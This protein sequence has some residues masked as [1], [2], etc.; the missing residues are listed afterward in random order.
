MHRGTRTRAARRRHAS[1]W[2]VRAVLCLGV[3]F[4]LAIPGTTAAWVDPVT[5]TGTTISTGT[6]HLQVEN[7]DAPTW[8]GMNATTMEAGDSTAGVMTV[9]NVGSTPLS[10]YVDAVATNSDGK[11]LAS[12]FD[13]NVRVTDGSST[14]T[15]GSSKTCNGTVLASYGTSFGAGLVG[16]RASSR[17]LPVNASETIC[18]QA[19]LPDGS[20]SD[21][22]ATNITFTF[23]ARTGSTAE[24]GWTDTVTVTG[25][26]LKVITAFYLD[27][28]STSDTP[29][30]DGLE[31]LTQASPMPKT[32][33]NYDV[34]HDDLPGRYLQRGKREGGD[35]A[36]GLTSTD[37]NKI[38]WFAMP[39]VDAPITVTGTPTLRIWTAAKDFK[40]DKA[41]ELY[42]G[43]YD[44]NSTLTDCGTSPIAVGSINSSP[45]WTGS[46][47][48]SR[49]TFPFT[50]LPSNSYTWAVGRVVVVRIMPSDA[51]AADMVF[52]YATKDFRSALIIQ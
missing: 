29:Q 9:K 28:Y 20:L 37:K 50:A 6:V 41:G 40:I 23:R 27:T 2:P 7:S 4:A 43:L 22:A 39:V 10:Y 51:E 31:P 30:N 13:G 1:S 16:S 52:A 44:C 5:V 26:T 42:A 32:L 12:R 36:K 46:T 21:G 17:S 11:G 8:T 45:A 48:W 33:Y 34:G 38:T 49:K 14:T 3:F 15:S 18:V 19:S 47:T 35:I 24:P 25:T